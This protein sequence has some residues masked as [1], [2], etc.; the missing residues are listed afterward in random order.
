[1]ILKNNS[2]YKK[3]TY[4]IFSFF[5]LIGI[6]K[7]NLNMKKLKQFIEYFWKDRYLLFEI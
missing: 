2:I 3:I 4:I 1:M 6:T 5:F 7:F